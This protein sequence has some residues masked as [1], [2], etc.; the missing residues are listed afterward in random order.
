MRV[1]FELNQM[2]LLLLMMIVVMLNLKELMM[3]D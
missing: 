2:L 1:E 3:K